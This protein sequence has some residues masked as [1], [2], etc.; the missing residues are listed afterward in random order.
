MLSAIGDHL[1]QSTLVAVAAALL[2]VLL[3]S[4]R[5]H[6]RHAIWLAAS[7]KF[8]VPFAALVAVGRRLGIAPPAADPE[9]LEIQINF[10]VGS[11]VR[12]FSIQPA[13]VPI[14]VVSTGT[15]W[16]GALPYGVAVVWAARET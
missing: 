8:L 2:T 10:V 11:V 15:D 9:R 6:V 5:A 4:N 12:P 7:L 16:L 1:W 14:S 13:D 3:R